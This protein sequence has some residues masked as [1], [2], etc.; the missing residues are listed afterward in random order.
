MSLVD[1][2]RRR[3]DA[4]QSRRAEVTEEDEAAARAKE[5][6]EADAV[7]DDHQALLALAADGGESSMKVMT[8]RRGAHYDYDTEKLK[9][10]FRLYGIQYPGLIKGTALIVV[11]RLKDQGLIVTLEFSAHSESEQ[12]RPSWTE[13]NLVASW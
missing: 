1:E 13:V 10:K 7:L 8:L 6:A 5:Q 11:N 3:T 12:D 4:A 2:L 9:R